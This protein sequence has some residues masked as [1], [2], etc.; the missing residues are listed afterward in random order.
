MPLI[1]GRFH[2]EFSEAIRK[3]VLHFSQRFCIRISNLPKSGENFDFNFDLDN[4]ARH[5][6]FVNSQVICQTPEKN[7]TTSRALQAPLPPLQV[8]QAGGLRL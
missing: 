6:Q 4:G 7:L 1:I 8:W 2:C 5:M 3:K